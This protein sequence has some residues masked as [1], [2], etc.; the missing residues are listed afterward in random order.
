MIP[1]ELLVLLGFALDEPFESGPEGAES[2]CGENQGLSTWLPLTYIAK[3]Y[4]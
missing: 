2:G 4:L 3:G 1:Q